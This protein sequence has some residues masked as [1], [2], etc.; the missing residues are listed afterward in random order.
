MTEEPLMP[1]ATQIRE[2]IQ[3]SEDR[4]VTQIGNQLNSEFTNEKLNEIHCVKV[5]N[6]VT[7]FEK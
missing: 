6:F 1:D 7:F 4:I 2:L 3:R 5:E